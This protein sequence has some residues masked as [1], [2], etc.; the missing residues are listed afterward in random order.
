MK[1]YNQ[2]RAVIVEPVRGE[3]VSVTLK[4]LGVLRKICDEKGSADS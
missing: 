3:A 4:L 1:P 2:N